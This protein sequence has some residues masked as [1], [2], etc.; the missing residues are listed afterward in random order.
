MQISLRIHTQSDQSHRCPHEE[1]LHPSL[2]KIRPVK[3]L[4]RWSNARIDLNIHWAN[5][6]EN[7]FSSIISRVCILV[8]HESCY[9]NMTLKLLSIEPNGNNSRP[10]CSAC[11]RAFHF[12]RLPLQNS[13][14]ESVFLSVSC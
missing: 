12:L 9:S 5:I 4:I 11:K 6:S 2:S 14:L 8:Y 7:M 10:Q 3:I 13:S 1:T